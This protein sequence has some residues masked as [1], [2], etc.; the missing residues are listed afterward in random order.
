MEDDETM[1]KHRPPGRLFRTSDMKLGFST[2]GCPSWP[3]ETIVARAREYGFDGF[4]I[5]GVMGEMDLLKVPELQPGRRAE[6]LR[7]ANDAGLEIMML[8]TG[9]RFSSASAADRQAN[10][11][12]AKA[13]MDL[14]R[15]MGVDKIRLYGGNIA[16]DVGPGQAYG[17]IA[18][19]LRTVAEYGATVG[20]AAAIETHDGFVDSFLVR[21]MLA[22]VDH[23]FLKVL[24]DVHHPWRMF[25]QT[26]AQCW[27][28]VGPQVVDTH[29]KDSYLTA[30]NKDGYRYCL[31][32][33]GDMPVR[34]AL[35]ILKAGGYDAYLTLEWEKAWKDYLAEPEVGFPQYVRQMRAYLAE[36]G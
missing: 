1:P 21:D 15:E 10:V 9:C 3:Y 35:R 28:N 6:T 4:E 30:D 20:V 14:A 12:E 17:W 24:W 23:P 26:P 16:S 8:M 32:G 5:R 2:L 22:R 27:E 18:E 31:L 25:G 13:N 33:D 7:M 29:F 36:L 19:C 11:D 34:D